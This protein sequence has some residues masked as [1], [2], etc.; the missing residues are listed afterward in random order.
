MLEGLRWQ[1]FI[2]IIIARLV[3]IEIESRLT[4]SEQNNEPKGIT[5]QDYHP[6]PNPNFDMWSCF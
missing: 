6:S 3:R 2:A 5:C 1:L 4:G